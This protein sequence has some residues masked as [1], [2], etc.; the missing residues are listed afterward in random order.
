MQCPVS[1]SL[2]QFIV[3]RSDPDIPLAMSSHIALATLTIILNL[4]LRRLLCVF[5]ADHRRLGVRLRHDDSD[6]YSSSDE[7]D[8]LGGMSWNSPCTGMSVEKVRAAY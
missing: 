1:Y 3:Q 7:Y 5:T 2:L 4:N 6:G 8:D